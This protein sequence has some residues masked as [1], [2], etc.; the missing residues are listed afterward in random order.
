MVL[1]LGPGPRDITLVYLPIGWDS[2]LG[3][4]SCVSGRRLCAN[5]N[6]GGAFD[7]RLPQDDSTSWVVFESN[8]VSSSVFFFSFRRHH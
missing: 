5:D 7:A 6:V 2:H 1:R 4:V 8:E 3:V